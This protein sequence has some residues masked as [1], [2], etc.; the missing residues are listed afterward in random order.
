MLQKLLQLSQLR[1]SICTNFGLLILISRPK[2]VHMLC[3]KKNDTGVARYNVNPHQSIMIIF[4]RDV[5][6]RVH[7]RTIVCYPTSPG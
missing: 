2:L 5:A 3:L 4:G 6:E 1:H 7:Y